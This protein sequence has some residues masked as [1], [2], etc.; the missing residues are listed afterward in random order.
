MVLLPQDSGFSCEK[1]CTDRAR[2]HSFRLRPTCKLCSEIDGHKVWFSQRFLT[3]PTSWRR[4]RA[5]TASFA[6]FN[7]VHRAVNFQTA[8]TSG[9]TWIRSGEGEAETQRRCAGIAFVVQSGV[10]EDLGDGCRSSIAS[11][12]MRGPIAGWQISMTNV[13]PGGRVAKRCS[14]DPGVNGMQGEKCDLCVAMAFQ[15]VLRQ[16]T[17][18]AIPVERELRLFCF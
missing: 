16:R 9:S 6:C 11:R 12:S 14:G 13:R 5:A 3:T 18:V 17:M 8:T 4:Q 10:P 2:D 7:R 1:H 15:F